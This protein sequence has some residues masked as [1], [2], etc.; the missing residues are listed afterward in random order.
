MIFV[1][2]ILELGVHPQLRQQQVQTVKKGSTQLISSGQVDLH[3][4]TDWCKEASWGVERL[5]KE[6]GETATTTATAKGGISYRVCEG[7]GRDKQN[8]ANY[9]MPRLWWKGLHLTRV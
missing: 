9:H 8:G 6:D 7:A 4:H 1:R 3:Q 5:R 2:R